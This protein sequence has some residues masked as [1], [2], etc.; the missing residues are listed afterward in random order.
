MNVPNDV[1]GVVSEKR[2]TIIDEITS[3][4]GAS[5]SIKG[6]Q[7]SR[8]RS[9]DPDSESI[10]EISGSTFAVTIAK[11]LITIA[12][13]LRD[14]AQDRGEMQTETELEKENCDIH[15]QLASR[16]RWV[17]INFINSKSFGCA[18]VM[19]HLLYIYYTYY[20]YSF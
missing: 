20:V 9:P 5:I 10:I 11:S 18:S 3:L 1:F 7:R 14:G 19:C 2:V 6:G 4:S 8:E 17:Y 16:S 15:T 12:L 13:D